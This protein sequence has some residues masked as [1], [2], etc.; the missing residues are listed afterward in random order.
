MSGRRL[1]LREPEVNRL[2]RA[3]ARIGLHYYFLIS[4]NNI[5][6]SA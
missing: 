4:I 5:E 1:S 2:L 6:N 3:G